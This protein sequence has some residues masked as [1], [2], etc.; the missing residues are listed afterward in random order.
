MI[1]GFE[2]EDREWTKHAACKDMDPN[3]FFRDPYTE[4][5]WT[6]NEAIEICQGCPVRQDCLDYAVKYRIQ[7]GIWG[8]LR[9]A[10]RRRYHPERFRRGKRAAS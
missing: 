4:G 8:G 5:E 6:A 1:P 2:T 7:Y 10:D 9:L 3:I